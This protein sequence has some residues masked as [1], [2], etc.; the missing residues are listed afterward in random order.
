MK[1]LADIRKAALLF[2]C[3]ILLIQGLVLNIKAQENDD[4]NFEQIT[5]GEL[6]LFANQGLKD[7]GDGSYSYELSLISNL[8]RDD[9]NEDPGVSKNAYFTAT[10]PGNYLIELYGGNGGDGSNSY[11]EGGRGGKGGHI[12]GVIRLEA[13]ETLYYELG[14]NGTSTTDV[15]GAGGANGDGGNHG[16]SGNYAVGTG[17]G[18][19]AVF[20]FAKGE[21]EEKYLRCGVDESAET[22]R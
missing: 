4:T 13:G 18:Y 9:Q 5:L 3:A 7:N 11:S 14:G 6:S 22:R 10:Q 17:G 12:Y 2:L 19:S 15:S 21:F 8:E 16:E 1:P 20:K